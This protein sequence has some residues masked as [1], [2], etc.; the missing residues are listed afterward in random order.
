MSGGHWRL[1]PKW[2]NEMALG[3]FFRSR[4]ASEWS[5]IHMA[6]VLQPMRALAQTTSYAGRR[7]AHRLTGNSLLNQ[8]FVN[9]RELVLARLE[10]SRL[11]VGV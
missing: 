10:L 8:T 5:A 1:A 2:E 4:L 6:W 3:L 7:S 9:V 11:T